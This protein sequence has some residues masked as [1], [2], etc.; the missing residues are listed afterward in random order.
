MVLPFPLKVTRF[1]AVAFGTLPNVNPA[2]YGPLPGI[3][4]IVTG[5]D[6]PTQLNSSI[7]VSKLV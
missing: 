5:P 1:V 4:F 2:L 7:K 3:T 6:T